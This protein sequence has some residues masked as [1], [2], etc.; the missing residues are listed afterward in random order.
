M[1][2]DSGGDL[3]TDMTTLKAN[4]LSL[5]AD[6]RFLKY[7]GSRGAYLTAVPAAL[8]ETQNVSDVIK[9]IGTAA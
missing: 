1:D 8:T 5:G 7:D 3:I 6:I 2:T 9:D 4:T